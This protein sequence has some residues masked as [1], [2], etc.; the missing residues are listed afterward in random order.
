MTTINR[1][2]RIVE[3]FDPVK[4]GLDDDFVLTKLT[5]MNGCGCKVPRDVLLQLLQTFKTDL[6]IN[7]DEVGMEAFLFSVQ[8]NIHIVSMNIHIV[9]NHNIPY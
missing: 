7:N 4:N 2:K 9:S 3:G 1:V 8:A 5:A 6:V